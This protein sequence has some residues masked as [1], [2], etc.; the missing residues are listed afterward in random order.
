MALL[1][2][3]E[4][5]GIVVVC[6]ALYIVLDRRISIARTDSG[7]ALNLD[8]KRFFLFDSKG[9]VLTL[10][11][12]ESRLTVKSPLVKAAMCKRTDRVTERAWSFLE[13]A[14]DCSESVDS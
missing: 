12:R 5:D 10:S 9:V 11:D 14:L 13:R 2:F 3:K 8:D 7:A 1:V 4:E 6:I